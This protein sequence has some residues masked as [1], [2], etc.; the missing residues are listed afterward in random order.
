[1]GKLQWE[2]LPAGRVAAIEDLTGSVL[3]AESV[4]SGLMPGLAAVLHAG[5]GR[6][7]LKAVPAT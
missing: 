1:M 6:Y 3:K 7:F 5:N 4:T 2:S